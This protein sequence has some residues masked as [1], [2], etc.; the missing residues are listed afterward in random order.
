MLRAIKNNRENNTVYLFPE[1][2]RKIIKNTEAQP[3]CGL[4]SLV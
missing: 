1:L 2:F 4:V 3:K